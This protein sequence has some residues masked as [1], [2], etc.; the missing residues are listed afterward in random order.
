MTKSAWLSLLMAQCERVLDFIR[1]C[2]TAMGKP[3]GHQLLQLPKL[4]SLAGRAGLGSGSHRLPC[5]APGSGLPIAFYVLLCKSFRAPLGSWVRGQPDGG[6]RTCAKGLLCSKAQRTFDWHGFGWE[7]R[8][9]SITHF[10][11]HRHSD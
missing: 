2:A 6:A 3:G 11:R 7:W 1:A 4:P 10:R 9:G 5:W 8:F